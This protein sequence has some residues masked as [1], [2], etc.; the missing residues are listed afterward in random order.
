MPNKHR[1]IDEFCT[2][3]TAPILTWPCRRIAA[4]EADFAAANDERIA[5]DR[6]ISERTAQFQ[7]LFSSVSELQQTF[8]DDDAALRRRAATAAGSATAIA[9]IDG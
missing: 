9:S 3:K 1:F 2:A 8:A 7:L 6:Q 4:V 5:L